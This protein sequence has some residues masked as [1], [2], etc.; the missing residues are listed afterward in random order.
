MDP[1]RILAVIFISNSKRNI[2]VAAKN[3]KLIAAFLSHAK[4]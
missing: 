2:L 3:E 4:F 1:V